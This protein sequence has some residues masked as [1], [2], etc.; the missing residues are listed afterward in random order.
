MPA[1]T[2]YPASGAG[3]YAEPPVDVA[4]Y[5]SGLDHEKLVD[6]ILG[7]AANDELLEA[8]LRLAAARGVSGGAPVDDFKAAIDDAFDTRGFVHYREMY[9][10]TSNIHTVLDTLGE[11]LTDG[12]ATV[13]IELAEHALARVEDAVGYVDDSDGYL[14]AIAS[15]LQAVHLDAC[16]IA[17]PDPLWLARRL[18]EWELVAGDLEIFYGAAGTYAGVLGEEG[19]AEYRRLAEA[20]WGRLPALAPGERPTYDSRRFSVTSMMQTLAEISGDVDAVVAVL[21]KDQSSAYQFVRIAERYREAGR[22]DDA[23]AWAER[24]LE[25]FGPRTDSRLVE[26]AAEEHHRAGRGEAAAELAWRAFESDPTAAD[27]ERL[28]A[29]ASRAG[30]WD[31]WRERALI[32]L[33]SH[34]GGR[35]KSAGKQSEATRSGTLYGPRADASELVRVFLFEGDAEQA[36]TEAKAGG[37]SRELWLE[38]AQRR[39]DTHPLDAIPLWQAEIERAVSAKNNASYAQAVELMDRVRRLMIAAERPEAFGS[40][41]ADVRVR[42]KPKRNLMKLLDQRGW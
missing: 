14:G 7:L 11:L 32:R 13:V 29:H 27:Y 10:Y 22:Y 30:S 12:H 28:C 40:C 3:E 42:H 1:P 5:L 33:R 19:L 17:R 20:E 6:L 18:F 39:E 25:A 24:G 26:A 21:A 34:V 15:D 23:L 38:L 4:S 35:M 31:A 41:A 9:D 2:K 16:A 37:C 36:W 8:R